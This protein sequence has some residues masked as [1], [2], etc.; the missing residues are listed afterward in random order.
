MYS[1]PWQFYILSY[2]VENFFTQICIKFSSVGE[3]K[4]SFSMTYPLP[5]LIKL[6]LKQQLA[7]KGEEQSAFMSQVNF[8][9]FINKHKHY[10]Q[11]HSG[12]LKTIFQR[13][14]SKSK[15]FPSHHYISNQIE[16]RKKFTLG[17]QKSQGASRLMDC[18]SS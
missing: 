2:F 8:F 17:F 6:Q 12:L 1:I 18:Y 10:F 13:G 15:L 14:L 16:I 11:N 3:S 9:L 7:G 5:T 4:R